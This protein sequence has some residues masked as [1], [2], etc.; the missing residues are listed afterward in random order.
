MMNE[1]VTE[2]WQHTFEIGQT[3]LRPLAEG[4]RRRWLFQWQLVLDMRPHRP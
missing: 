4:A 2:V 1:H 3:I